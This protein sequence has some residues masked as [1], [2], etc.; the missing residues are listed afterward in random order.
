V[1]LIDYFKE[2]LNKINGKVVAIDCD[3]TAPALL[4]ADLYEIVPRI[5]HPE[6]LEHI[7]K[8]CKKHEIHAILSLIDPELALLAS[9]KEEFEEKNIHIVVSDKKVVDICYDKYLTY[10]FLQEN[11]LPSVPTYN[12][13]D[14][15]INDLNNGELK[16]PLIVK[17]KNGSASLGI[18]KVNSIN[19]LILFKEAAEDIIVQAF[20]DGQEYGVDCYVDLLSRQ[21]TNIFIKRKITMRAGETD[22]SVSLKDLR[23]IR[24]I[25]K[26]MEALRPIGPIDID[27][28][29]TNDE[30]LISEINPRF[31]GGYLHAHELGQNFV[32]NIINNLK[33]EPNIKND[34]DYE[35]GKIM[36]KFDNPIIL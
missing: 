3:S 21:T 19:E 36:V 30:Y 7:K 8:I 13:I 15:V 14:K 28:F 2:E 24:L 20:V 5:D 4:K 17:P 18:N 27:C 9:V 10:Q 25:E 34:G 11:D 6:Y 33:G 12:D 31:G 22:K 29:N 16:F 32:V 26:L 1:K 35:E 23:L